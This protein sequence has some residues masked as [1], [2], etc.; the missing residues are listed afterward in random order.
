MGD[1]GNAREAG[2]NRR[3]FGNCQAAGH[4]PCRAAGGGSGRAAVEPCA[5]RSCP[6]HRFATAVATACA[7][8]ACATRPGPH[9][10][11]D[12][13]GIAP[14]TWRRSAVDGDA[15]YAPGRHGVHARQAHST[16]VTI[17]RGTSNRR[18]GRPVDDAGRRQLAGIAVGDAGG[19]PGF[20]GRFAYAA[21]TCHP[22]RVDPIPVVPAS[23]TPRS[24]CSRRIAALGRR[25]RRRGGHAVA[26]GGAPHSRIA[27]T[28]GASL[29]HRG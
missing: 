19:R 18:A 2:R 8:A 21:I 7:E 6:T 28:H 13:A 24:S 14:P 9:A 25:G 15:T 4:A 29:S 17:A 11:A 12:A 3:K 23:P 10:T 1:Q 22:I 5:W 26:D 16:V 20:R 27:A